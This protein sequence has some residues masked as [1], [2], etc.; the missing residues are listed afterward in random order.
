MADLVAPIRTLLLVLVLSGLGSA[1]VGFDPAPLKRSPHQ[2]ETWL[3]SHKPEIARALNPPSSREALQRFAA[4]RGVAFPEEVYV[5]YTWHNG[6]TSGVALFGDYRFQP[7]EEALDS[8]DQAAKIGKDAYRLP[9]FQSAL[10]HAN[11]QVVC[12]KTP[13]ARAPVDWFFEG[14]QRETPTLATFAAVLAACFEKG[15]FTTA[16]NTSEASRRAFYQV[17]LDHLPE[18]KRAVEAV[19]RGNAATLAPQEQ[20]QA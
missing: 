20:V 8:A 19:L 18:R 14:A 13:T 7:I 6:M 10:D 5:L 12:R 11:Y 3:G 17:L 15:V 1:Q 4:K 2:I 16:G 9:L